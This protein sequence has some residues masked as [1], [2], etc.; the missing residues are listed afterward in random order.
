M[1]ARFQFRVDF[2]LTHICLGRALALASVTHGWP[3]SRDGARKR[4]RRVLQNVG[5]HGLDRWPNDLVGDAR[6]KRAHTEAA[7]WFDAED[8][9]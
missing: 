6:M 8:S 1:S 4:V 7:H 9:T 3:T 2:D 5:I